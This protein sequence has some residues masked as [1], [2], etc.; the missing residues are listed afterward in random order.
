VVRGERQN[1]DQAGHY[2]RPD[3]LKLSVDRRRQSAV[4]FQD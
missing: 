2:A 1:L 3:V 4:V